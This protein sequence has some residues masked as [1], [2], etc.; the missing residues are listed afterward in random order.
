MLV[1]MR[2]AQPLAGI[3]VVSMALNAPG[4]L[5]VARLVAEG[6]R[7][8]KIEPPSGD[9]LAA[10]CPSW[11][12]E[13]HQGVAVE[14]LDLKAPAGMAR[15]IALLGDADVFLSSQRPK[16]LARLGLEATTLSR[17][18]SLNIVGERAHPDAPGHDLTYQARAGLLADRLPASLFADVIGSER[19]FSAV[20]LLLRQPPGA[21]AEIG[22]YDSLA[23]FVATSRH[24]L[25]SAGG[26][27]GGGLPAYG[28]Y[29]TRDGSVAIAALEPHFRARLYAALHLRDGSDLSEVMTTRT[30][31]EWEE[32]AAER[33]LPMAVVRDQNAHGG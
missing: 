29:R 25:T 24:G 3:R 17:V 9:P 23:P 26:I 30:A 20:L 21:R 19:A 5:A 14:R 27:L 2:A 28:I 7:G 13:L 18:R 32:W 11:Y 1:V 10:I 16:A 22:I 8:V 12:H 4:P 31:V 15:M 6:A 33:D